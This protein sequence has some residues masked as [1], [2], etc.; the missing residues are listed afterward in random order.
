MSVIRNLNTS[1]WMNF[2]LI[3]L[4]KVISNQFDLKMPP[5]DRKTY[6]CGSQKS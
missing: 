6:I 5:K 2:S 3:P 1:F 4:L